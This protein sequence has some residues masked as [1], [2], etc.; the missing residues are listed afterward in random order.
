[1]SREKLKLV[2]ILLNPQSGSQPGIVERNLSLK[3]YIVARLSNLALTV[4]I[5]TMEMAFKM[6]FCSEISY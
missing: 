2:E 4:L 6:Q 3:L 1:M 5:F